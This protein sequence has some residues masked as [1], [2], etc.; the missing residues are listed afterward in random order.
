MRVCRGSP[1]RVQM[2]PCP[3]AIVLAVE[4]VQDTGR[5]RAAEEIFILGV[6]LM[7]E[8]LEQVGVSQPRQL[9]SRRNRHCQ[10]KRD[11]SVTV[12]EYGDGID[13]TE[14]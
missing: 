4:R 5:F 3:R 14:R 10:R 11:A 9:T 13:I 12:G 1:G 2:S 7:K 8:A 6:L